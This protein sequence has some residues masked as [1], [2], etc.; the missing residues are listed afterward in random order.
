MLADLTV[1][2]ALAVRLASGTTH[3]HATQNAPVAVP[4]TDGDRKWERARPA[5]RSR[6]LSLSTLGDYE[7]ATI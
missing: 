5:P 6:L 4:L 7:P 2:D 3:N 1:L